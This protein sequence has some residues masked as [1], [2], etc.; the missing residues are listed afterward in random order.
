ARTVRCCWPVRWAWTGRCGSCSWRRPAAGRRPPRCWPRSVACP[1]WV[2]WR[3]ARRGLRTGGWRGSG[4]RTRGG[5]SA[6][7]G[8]PPEGGAGWGGRWRGRGGLGGGGG[9][10]GGRGRGGG[11][12]GWGASGAG[13]SWLLRAGL[14]P[15]LRAAGLAGVPGAAW[16]PQ[17]VFTPTR[18][19][20]E[21]LALQVAALAGADAAG[22]A[23]ELAAHP[24][25]FALTA[26]QAA[27][28]RPRGPAEAAGGEQRRRRRLLLV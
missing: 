27:L 18:A 17:V 21:E 13:K 22:V 28:A 5:F 12:G 19:P 10:G 20:L 9:G 23:R 8:P 25:G 1:V 11:R 14:V 7:G 4:G 3:A 15:R 26:R 6:G 2:A 16:W 24:E